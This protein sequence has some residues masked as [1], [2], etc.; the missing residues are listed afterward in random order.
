MTS[1]DESVRIAKEDAEDLCEKLLKCC[2]RNTKDV[3][4]AGTEANVAL[5]ATAYLVALLINGIGEGSLV[6]KM[7]F[8]SK[9]G[10]IVSNKLFS[11]HYLQGE[12]D[13]VGK[14]DSSPIWS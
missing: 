5:F 14:G 11:L 7:S 4:I 3:N 10:E 6:K 8:Y 12:K 2:I 1:P 13:G 9:V